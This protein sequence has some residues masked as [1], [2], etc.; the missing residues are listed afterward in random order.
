M[1]D[2]TYLLDESV[3]KLRE[4]QALELKLASPLPVGSTPEEVKQRQEDEG[5]LA[6]LE[7]Q[8]GSYVSLGNE[9]VYMLN[10]LTANTAIVAGFMVN[11]IVERLAA[12]L[13]FNLNSLVGPKCMELKVRSPEKYRFNPKSLLR[14]IVG[15]YL[16]LGHREEFILAVARDTRSYKRELFAKAARVLS[17]NALLTEVCAGWRGDLSLFGK[18]KPYVSDFVAQ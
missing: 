17:N 12:M 7:R 1:N 3:T 16:H 18:R 6:T 13:D 8:A 2:T 5:T 10:Y 14:D 9:T 15:I 4:I 11:E